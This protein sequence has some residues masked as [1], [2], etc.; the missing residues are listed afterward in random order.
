[1][2]D[3]EQKKGV[4]RPLP[5]ERQQM[6]GMYV[7]QVLLTP[8]QVE[9]DTG[10][11]DYELLGHFTVYAARAVADF[12]VLRAA[13]S[14]IQ[15]PLAQSL[16]HAPAVML[17][18]ALRC[19]ARGEVFAAPDPVIESLRNLNRAW[20]DGEQ[21][22]GKAREQWEQREELAAQIQPVTSDD[23]FTPTQ[24]TSRNIIGR[25]KLRAV[26]QLCTIAIGQD[27]VITLTNK[28]P[29]GTEVQVFE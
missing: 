19:P 1:M 7:L 28:S 13:N 15:L 2:S 3:A 18:Y 25:P 29:D 8:R 22:V 21:S 4:W 5:G 6:F 17:G 27:G 16:A 14:E 20:R 10:V 23:P 11:K 26:Q 12:S 9:A 24:T